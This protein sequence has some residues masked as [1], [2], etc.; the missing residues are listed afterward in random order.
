[1]WITVSNLREYFH[2]D[3]AAMT[4]S[5]WVGLITTIG[6]F[7]LFIALFVYVLNP[8]NKAN[9]EAKRHIPIDEDDRFDAEETK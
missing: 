9:L 7:L 3:W 4:R 8:K 5:D 2:T 6:I 1:M